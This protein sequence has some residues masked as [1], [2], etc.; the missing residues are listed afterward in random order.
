M[1]RNSAF[2]VNLFVWPVVFILFIGMA[3]FILP[4]NCV[5]RVTMG[6]LL[7]LTLVIM[8]LMLDAYTP[9]SSSKISIIGKLIAYAMFMITW[10]TCLSTVILSLCKDS[11]VVNPIPVS[12]KNVDFKIFAKI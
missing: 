1:K 5:E 8:S 7:I 2:Y 3:L 10:S 6:V 12:L 4:P 11:F 9:K